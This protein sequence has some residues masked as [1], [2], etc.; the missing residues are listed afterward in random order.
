MK[1]NVD[2]AGAELGSRLPALC[3]S[4]GTAGSRI[5]EIP[6]EDGGTADVTNTHRYR[7]VP[8]R[9]RLQPLGGLL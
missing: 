9:H 1:C 8:P 5:W 3:V 7:N 6:G 2:G 4:W